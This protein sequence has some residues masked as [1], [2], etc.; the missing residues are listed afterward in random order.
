MATENNSNENQ[1][2][3][4]KERSAWGHIIRGIWRTPVG[5]FA[6]VMTTVSITLMLI[7]M[8]A[9]VS[10]FFKNPY[11]GIFVYMILPGCMVLGLLLI[12]VA[13]YLRRREWRKTGV[14]KDHLQ[15]TSV[16]RNTGF[17]WSG[18]SC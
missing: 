3:P 6:I 11:V 1:Q 12:P 15:L 10:G 18:S 4:R 2:H 16:I 5:V 9:E 13:A 14:E 17:S 8:V 7:G